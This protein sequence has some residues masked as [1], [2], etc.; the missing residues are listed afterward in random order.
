MEDLMTLVKIIAGAFMGIF[1]LILLVLM[2]V[3]DNIKNLHEMIR[4]KWYG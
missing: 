1:L 2:G 3:R 4:R